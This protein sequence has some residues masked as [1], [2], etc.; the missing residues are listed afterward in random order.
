MATGR[1]KGSLRMWKAASTT[2]SS[3]S[4][5]PKL[6]S[7]VSLEVEGLQLTSDDEPK[8]YELLSADEREA[9]TAIWN[10]APEGLPPETGR[11]NGMKGHL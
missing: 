9:K 11:E 4:R 10:E 5:P 3:A 2:P 1:V 6:S 8:A 7:T